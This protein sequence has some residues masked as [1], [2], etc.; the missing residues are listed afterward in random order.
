MTEDEAIAA[1]CAWGKQHWPVVGDTAH[2]VVTVE[3]LTYCEP[4]QWWE[5][6]LA[7]AGHPGSRHVIFWQADAPQNGLVVSMREEVMG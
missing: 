7:V 5:A 1:I 4:E 3:R 6:T 2:P